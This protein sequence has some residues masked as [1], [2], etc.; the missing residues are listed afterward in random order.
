MKSDSVKKSLDLKMKLDSISMPQLQDGITE[1]FVITNRKFLRRRMGEGASASDID[2]K[3]R[4]LAAQVFVENNVS[5]AYASIQ[6]L[7]KAC[8][9]L[10]DQLGFETNPEMAQHHQNIIGRLFELASSAN[11]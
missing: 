3:T 1:C 9:I 2:E 7:H 4:D 11:I 5:A 10:E 6:D 8:S